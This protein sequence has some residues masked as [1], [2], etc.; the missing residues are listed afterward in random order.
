MQRWTPD[1]SGRKGKASLGGKTDSTEA[2]L[3]VSQIFHRL[4][5]DKYLHRA[6]FHVLRE[7]AQ[8][9]SSSAIDLWRAFVLGSLAS[10]QSFGF[11]ELATLANRSTVIR[12]ALGHQSVAPATSYTASKI[13]SLVQALP[14]DAINA[15]NNLV[16]EISLRQEEALLGLDDEPR[17]PLVPDKLE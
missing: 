8:P 9:G 13:E 5:T 1:E 11:E 14:E 4:F 12:E 15:L 10:V 3:P 2:D 6:V 16:L 7:F 17:P